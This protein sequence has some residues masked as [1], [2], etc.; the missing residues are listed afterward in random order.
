MCLVSAATTVAVSLLGTL[1]SIAKREARSTS[2][3]T[4][5]DLEDSG[6][7][8][9]FTGVIFK[10]EAP[11]IPNITSYNGKMVDISGTIKEYKGKPEIIISDHRI[12]TRNSLCVQRKPTSARPD[13]APQVYSGFA[14]SV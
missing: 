13:R 6:R 3:T 12:C 8:A 7:S 11:T 1:R 10:D 4:F 14:H 2:G 9:P 5:V